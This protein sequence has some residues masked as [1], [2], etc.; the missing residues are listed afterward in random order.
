LI[1]KICI[2]K[3]YKAKKVLRNFRIKAGDCGEETEQTFEE[4]AINGAQRQ[5]EAAALQAYR[6]SLAFL[7][8]NIHTQLDII[9]KECVNWL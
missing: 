9:R 8:C 2:L 1:K 4:A 5:N 7:F 3:G 6:I